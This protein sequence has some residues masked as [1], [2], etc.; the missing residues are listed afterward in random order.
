[1]RSVQYTMWHVNVRLGIGQIESAKNGPTLSLLS[2]N[3]PGE[4]LPRA[5]EKRAVKKDRVSCH[6]C[7]QYTAC[8]DGVTYITSS[9]CTIESI[10]V[11]FRP[12]AMG[13]DNVTQKVLRPSRPKGHDWSV[14]C[15]KVKN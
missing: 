4:M 3:F 12:D 9:S 7:I 8:D 5:G 13:C 6:S 15:D 10:T 1:M 11:L 2:T 14:M